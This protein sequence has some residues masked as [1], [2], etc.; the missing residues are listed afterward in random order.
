MLAC[1]S[2]S[3][4]VCTYLFGPLGLG[5]AS[6]PTIPRDFGAFKGRT[7]SFLRRTI[8]AAPIVRM[9][10]VETTVSVMQYMQ[11]SMH[12]PRMISRHIDML[13]IGRVPGIKVHGGVV[14]VLSQ[15]VPCSEDACCHILRLALDS[16]ILTDCVIL[17][18]IRASET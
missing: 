12:V 3:Q 1:L 16:D 11:P 13:S 6:L 18:F 17:T 5:P 15:E 2:Q 8:E 14:R 7:P 4:R 10:L 9:R